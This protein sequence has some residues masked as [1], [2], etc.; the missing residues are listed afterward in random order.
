MVL[1]RCKNTQSAKRDI[2][3]Y[4]N[5]KESF[6]A[7]IS[8]VSICQL[9]FWTYLGE[10]A[11]SELRDPYSSIK[12]NKDKKKEEL[13][14]DDS[15]SISRVGLATVSIVAGL[16]FCVIGFF[17]CY[18]SVK[19]LALTRGGIDVKITTYGP[20]GMHRQLTVPLSNMSAMAKRN[21]TD[22]PIPIRIRNYSF[23]FLVDHQGKFLEPRLY[24]R[25][26][27]IKRRL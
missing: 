1:Q 18:R 14:L 7:T 2:V 17:Y 3:I 9:F 23:Y 27:S 19:S 20:F 6:F 8:V 4:T 12:P 11:F 26:I 15:D 24:D 21:E 25:T 16:S 10:F 13:A 5:K 22:S